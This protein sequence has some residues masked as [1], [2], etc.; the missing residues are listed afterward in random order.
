MYLTVPRKKIYLKPITKIERDTIVF[1]AIDEVIYYQPCRKNLNKKESSNMIP[2]QLMFLLPE[3]SMRRQLKRLPKIGGKLLGVRYFMESPTPTSFFFEE[4]SALEATEYREEGLSDLLYFVTYGKDSLT[5]E[6]KETYPTPLTLQTGP[7]YA[8]KKM[9]PVYNHC[10]HETT[11]Y[12]N[13][14]WYIVRELQE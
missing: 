7:W 12:T 10:L 3:E 8:R 2:G 4:L 11:E 9:H 5:G 6:E 1:N 13:H 14:R